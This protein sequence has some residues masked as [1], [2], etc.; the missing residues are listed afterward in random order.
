MGLLSRIFGPSREKSLEGQYPT[1]R[2]AGKKLGSVRYFTGRLCRNGHVAYR[3]SSSGQCVTCLEIW[4]GKWR[5]ENRDKYLE[6]SAKLRAAN[7]Q[8]YRD[9]EAAWRAK[10]MSKAI[11][12]RIQRDRRSRQRQASGS[13]SLDDVYEVIRLQRSKCAYCRNGLS[14]YEVDHI[15]PLA[16]G[17]SNNRSNIQITCASCN[18]RKRSKDPMKFSREIGRLL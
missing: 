14:S 5:S 4:K 13:H 17:G 9:S 6:Q 3:F 2:A 16:L 12:S 1:S 8:K 7:P 18:R 10:P 11:K 15:V